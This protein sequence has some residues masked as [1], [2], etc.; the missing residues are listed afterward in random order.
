MKDLF[1]K[2]EMSHKNP[3]EVMKPVSQKVESPAE[4]A[5]YLSELVGI[6]YN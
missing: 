3:Y 1:Y 2:L 5:Q 6:S 4:K